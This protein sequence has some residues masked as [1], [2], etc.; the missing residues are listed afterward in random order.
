LTSLLGVKHIRTTPYHPVSN[1]L[2]E[3][4]HRSLK[5]S[6][7]CRNNP[8]WTESLPLVLLGLRSAFKT[9]LQ[10]TTAEL[11][12]GSTL[13]LPA[14]FLNPS[15][16]TETEPSTFLSQL[17]DNMQQLSP[18]PASSHDKSASFIHPALETCTHV[19]LRRDGIRKPLQATFEGP[20]K[21]LSRTEKHFTIS[22]P[23]RTVTV[24]IDR[25]KPAFLLNDDS[26]LPQPP[27]TSPV[28]NP[29][30]V[31]DVPDNLVP[32]PDV[33]VSPAPTT[34]RSGRRVRFNP[35]YL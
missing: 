4:F 29:A 34:T 12:Y 33:P 18:T 7:K 28:T 22:L 5:Q 8:R 31:S 27:G 32:S 15:T 20:Y 6:L 17:R 25:L 30:P 14:E 9:D 26:A 3:R 16:T 23:N 21:V 35:R 19:F 13:R 10:C 24:S 2:V 1:G 11:V